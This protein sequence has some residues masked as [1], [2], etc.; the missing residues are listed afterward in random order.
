MSKA[1]TK[2]EATDAFLDHCR[3]IVK[4]WAKQD[5]DSTVEEMISGAVFSVL[6][7]IDGCSDLP[8]MDLVLRP[9]PDDK[10]DYIDGGDNWVVD[11]MVIN[12]DCMLHDNFYPK[13]G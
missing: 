2:E 11:G 3:T 8:S 5:K 10:Q 12:D 9:H 13:A 4:Y 6:T 1:I 7:A